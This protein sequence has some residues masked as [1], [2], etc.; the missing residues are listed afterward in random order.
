MVKSW[1]VIAVELK[2]ISIFIWSALRAGTKLDTS[3]HLLQPNNYTYSQNSTMYL[4]SLMIINSLLTFA[5]AL[6]IF[7]LLSLDSYGDDDGDVS[8]S[9]AK[10]EPSGIEIKTCFQFR[11]IIPKK[12]MDGRGIKNGSIFAQAKSKAKPFGT[13]L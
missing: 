13:M 10:D 1:L 8:G 2:S 9:K 12:I 5:R 7:F 4:S 3:P 6:R 11:H